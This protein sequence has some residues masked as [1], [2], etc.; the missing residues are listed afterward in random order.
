MAVTAKL[1]IT[2]EYDSRHEVPD[3]EDLKEIVEQ[4][5]G[6]GKVVQADLAYLIPSSIDLL[7]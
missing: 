5:R 1:T 4:L 3:T 6:S 2:V 7:K